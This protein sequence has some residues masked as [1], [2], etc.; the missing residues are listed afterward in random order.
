ML[1]TTVKYEKRSGEITPISVKQMIREVRQEVGVLQPSFL[2]KPLAEVLAIV[3]KGKYVVRGDVN[4]E[5]DLGQAEKTVRL[6]REL[7]D[8]GCQSCDYRGEHYITRC[9]EFVVHSCRLLEKNYDPEKQT[10]PEDSPLVIKHDQTPCKKWKPGFKQ[11]LEE[12]LGE[13]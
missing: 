12:L 2:R 5:I 11:K 7:S 6:Y 13:D 3:E 9:D 8:G 10:F 1:S 4:T